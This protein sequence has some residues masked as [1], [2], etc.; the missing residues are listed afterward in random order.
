MNKAKRLISILLAAAM[1][2]TSVPAFVFAG[3]MRQYGADVFRRISN[4]ENTERE[5]DGIDSRYNSYIFS[6]E[7]RGDKLYIATNR[8]MV[9]IVL[10]MINAKFGASG[11]VFDYDTVQA[12]A[13]LVTDY[14]TP[15]VVGNDYT[16]TVFVYDKSAKTFTELAG[17]SEA[18]GQE[19]SD[20]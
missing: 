3:D 13:D 16:G 2:V 6:I 4:P 17:A 7:E 15:K 9:G 5:V 20:A 10:K 8:N 1:L 12:I 11:I 18:E 19:E 14:D